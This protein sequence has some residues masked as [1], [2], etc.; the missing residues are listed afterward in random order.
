MRSLWIDISH[1]GFSFSYTLETTVFVPIF[2]E[3]VKI[4]IL[5]IHFRLFLHVRIVL[6]ELFVCYF[7]KIWKQ[8]QKTRIK[9]ITWAVSNSPET[10]NTDQS[11]VGFEKCSSALGHFQ[12]LEKY[13]KTIWRVSSC[14]V[15]WLETWLVY[16]IPS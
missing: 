13:L 4:L 14:C 5:F 8:Q 15:V 6:T 10:S 9:I 16:T 11:E 12:I 7:S 2:G 3:L 1:R